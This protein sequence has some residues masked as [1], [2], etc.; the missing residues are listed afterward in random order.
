MNVG[1]CG[2]G[3]V[4]ILAPDASNLAQVLNHLQSNV[5]RFRRFNEF[6]TI[7]FPQIKQISVLPIE[8]NRVRIL[9]WTID[10]NQERSDLA[11]PLSESGTG[12]GQVLAILYVVITSDYPRT[13]VID[14][15][16]SFLHP[17]AVRKLFDILKQHPQHQYIV[18]T[19]SPTAVTATDPKTIFLLRKG[20]VESTIEVVDVAETQRLRLFLSEIG[21]RLSD[22]FGAD[23]ILWVEGCTEELCFPLILLRIADQPL[24][25]TAIIGVKQ[26]G[27]FEGKLSRTIFE[28]YKRLSEGRGLLP[29]AIGFIFDKEGRTE[30]EREDLVRESQG[31]V[32]FTPRRMYENYLLNPQA[33]AS[34]ISRI[35]EFRDSE[36]TTEEV[37][38]W[39]QNKRWDKKY[40][41]TKISQ[42]DR[43]EEMWFEKVAWG[44]N[45]GRYI[46][47]TLR[48]PSQL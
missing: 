15:P 22:V 2:V 40:F 23:D 24:L 5:I 16:Q 48:E 35:E 10:P 28:I 33:I 18:T 1:E 7:I 42:A 9:V 32:V 20:E 21:A 3:H 43:T 27:D 39:L 36:V 44:E 6:V 37:E 19:H 41:E 4:P 13:I 38:E 11:M 29:P 26:T 17:G 47:T 8:N 12:I 46:Q 34:V 30:R 45:I 31:T 25:G 14:E